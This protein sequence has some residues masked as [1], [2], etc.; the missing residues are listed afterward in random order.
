MKIHEIGQKN[1]KP[2]KL[3]QQYVYRPEIDPGIDLAMFWGDPSIFQ[4][5]MSI[6]HCFAFFKKHD[7]FRKCRCFGQNRVFTKQHLGS[8]DP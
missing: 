1:G 6:F 2:R 5:V 4:E 3:T 7:I 8:V